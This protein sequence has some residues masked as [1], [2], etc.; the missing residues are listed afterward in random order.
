MAEDDTVKANQHYVPKFYLKQFATPES[1]NNRNPFIWVLSN[2]YDHGEPS[3]KSIKS[4]S[5]DKY[6]YSPEDEIG[7]RCQKMDGI[8]EHIENDISKFWPI[9]ANN[10]VNFGN[11]KKMLAIFIASLYLRNIKQLDDM[12]NS[13]NDFINAM[14]FPPENRY[15]YPSDIIFKVDDKTIKIDK[16]SFNAYL[17]PAQDITHEM[18]VNSISSTPK[19][20]KSLGIE[21]GELLYV[22][23]CC[24]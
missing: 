6:I 5:V 20:A 15:R 17:N 16:E 2:N 3:K 7:Q 13:R 1:I 4:Q 11:V 9:L 23:S 10:N 18:F 22:R 14:E 8:L 24:V 21:F 19:L 12:R